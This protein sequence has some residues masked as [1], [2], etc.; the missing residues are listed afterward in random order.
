MY[1]GGVAYSSSFRH[2]TYANYFVTSHYYSFSRTYLCILLLLTS[3]Y[4][5]FS[6]TCLCILLLLTSCYYKFSRTCLC[7]LL[8]LTSHYYNS[9]CTYL[10]LLLL[11][12]GWCR[13]NHGMYW[14]NA[15]QRSCS[16]R[17]T[18]RVDASR[19]SRFVYHYTSVFA[20]S[21]LN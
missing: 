8:L 12:T 4:Y 5:S 20:K 3:R 11:L 18:K 1:M 21:E 10:C 13:R 17:G 6:R 16:K 7:T 15:N 14:S 9:S 19:R 2:I